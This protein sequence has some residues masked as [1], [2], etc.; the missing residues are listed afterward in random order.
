VGEDPVVSPTAGVHADHFI[1]PYDMVGQPLVFLANSTL[2]PK[3]STVLTP[4][5]T[6]QLGIALAEIHRFFKAAYGT[7]A[8]VE[9]P[10]RFGRSYQTPNRLRQFAARF[11]SFRGFGIIAVQVVKISANSRDQPAIYSERGNIAARHRHQFPL[12]N[13]PMPDGFR[14]RRTGGFIPMRSADNEYGGTGFA[15]ITGVAEGCESCVLKQRIRGKKGRRRRQAGR[16]YAETSRRDKFS[17]YGNHLC[18]RSRTLAKLHCVTQQEILSPFKLLRASQPSFNIP[19]IR[20][21][22]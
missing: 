6:N 4:V 12:L 2:V 17:Q 5:Q 10:I 16:L 1:Y 19:R 22:L 13:R 9:N 15:G 21:S 3:G 18:Q 11:V 14:R 8:E 7:E 20:I